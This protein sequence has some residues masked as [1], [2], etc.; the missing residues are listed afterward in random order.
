MSTPTGN[1]PTTSRR[2]VVHLLRHGEVHNPGGV[3]YGRLPDYHLSERGQAMAERLA[4]H[5]EHADLVHLRCS[6]LER[7]QE[8]MAPIAAAHQLPV[9]TDGRVIEG[10]NLFE[11]KVFSLGASALRQPKSWWLLRNPLRPSWGE[12]YRDIV[13]RMRAAMK[14]AAEA[15]T[16]HEALIVT[17]QLPI[18]MA[19][20]DVEGRHLVHDPRKRECTLASLTSF[21]YLDGRITSVSYSEPA[22]DLLPIGKSKKFVAGA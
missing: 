17:H 4:K 18:W 21:T 7:A 8:T 5:L 2:T 19:R 6:P 3:L 13:V 20:R 14:D 15:A 12:P 22:A 9:V 16:G 11:G 10:D 1:D